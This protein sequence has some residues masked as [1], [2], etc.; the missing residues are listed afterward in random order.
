M[1]K[2]SNSKSLSRSLSDSLFDDIYN[3]HYAKSVRSIRNAYT[4]SL[5]MRGNLTEIA[6]Q[7]E[8]QA[9]LRH[10]LDTKF[11]NDKFLE[12]VR[13]CMRDVSS[14]YEHN[15]IATFVTDRNEPYHLST[16]R[17]E[18]VRGGTSTTI[19]SKSYKLSDED[20]LKKLA[21]YNALEDNVDLTFAKK[22]SVPT[23][24]DSTTSIQ[25]VTAQ[26][27][28]NRM[29][30]S[31]KALTDLVRIF[32]S[33]SEARFIEKVNQE[34]ITSI[35]QK[36]LDDHSAQEWTPNQYAALKSN[37]FP[38]NRDDRSPQTSSEYMVNFV[39]CLLNFMSPDAKKKLNRS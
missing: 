6:A 35:F 4:K 15:P 14:R 28:P 25:T 29:T 3:L 26:K 32:E 2:P 19:K 8:F 10:K 33:L 27:K 7:N 17:N 34:L 5:K 23:T 13:N 1:K 18:F 36:R 38:T 21:E 20:L 16:L 39:N 37:A 31:N 12:R 9:T 30:V 22:S 11:R 24:N